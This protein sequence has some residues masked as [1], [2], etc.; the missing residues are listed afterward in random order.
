MSQQRFTV[1]ISLLPRLP[2]YRHRQVG[3]WHFP[4]TEFLIQPSTR[5]CVPRSSFLLRQPGVLRCPTIQF[6]AVRSMPV[7]VSPPGV[8]RMSHLL[9][10]LFPPVYFTCNVFYNR[11][12]FFSPPPALC[13]AFSNEPIF[14]VAFHSS[15]C[16]SIC[17]VTPHNNN[18]IYNTPSQHNASS[19]LQKHNDLVR[20]NLLLHTDIQTQITQ[21]LTNILRHNK[22]QLYTRK[23]PTK[24]LRRYRRQHTVLL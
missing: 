6:L 18:T 5:P 22:M 16:D 3:V 15:F 20:R 12:T 1:D 24:Y 4:A 8:R 9:E 11:L 10:H 14:D 17:N 13:P 19:T 21:V 7:C 2:V 23:I